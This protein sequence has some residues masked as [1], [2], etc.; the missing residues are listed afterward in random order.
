MSRIAYVAGR[1]VPHRQAGV[2]IE[3]R[4]YQFADGVYEVI[5][6]QG[7]HLVDEAPH[8]AR[9]QRS[10][11]ELR[12]APPIGDAA[13]K[14]V[15]RE[16]IRR[17]D[18]DTG[19]VYL[20]VTRGVA[21]REHAF[22]KAAKPT[23]VVTSRRSRPPD[24]RLGQ[25][26]IAVITIRDIRWQR[27][28]IK[29]IALVANVLGKQQ[30]KETGAW[31][32]WQVDGDG[33]VTEGTSTNAWIVTGDGAVVTRAADHTILNGVTRRAVI[34]I[35]AHDGYRLVER[36]FTVAEAKAAREAFLT[37]TTADLL[38]VVRIDDTPVGNGA[39]G[40]LS[41]KLRAAYFSHAAAA[42]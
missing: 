42:P 15:I 36:P 30:A 6:V 27:C 7:G 23:L 4:G 1:F 32:A 8:L 41:E 34:D 17:N 19:I 28:D 37:S 14:I 22:P 10:L 20:Q 21:P 38:P 26:G 33:Y 3:D 5:A 25:D 18:V 2:H 12:I 35:I 39:P 31:E 24:P 9:L 13:L 16:V 29:S 40:L 11:A